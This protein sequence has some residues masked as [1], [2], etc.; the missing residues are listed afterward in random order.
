MKRWPH[1]VDANQ[2]PIVEI[3]RSSGVKVIVTSHIG[4]GFPD[5]VC[6]FQGQTEMLEIKQPGEKLTPAEQEFHDRWR[7][8]RIRIVYTRGDALAVFGINIDPRTGLAHDRI[9]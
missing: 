4:G 7:G 3:L 6:G 1:K 8:R 2:A 5:L 9:Y